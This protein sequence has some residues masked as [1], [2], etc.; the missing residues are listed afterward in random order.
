MQNRA[1]APPAPKAIPFGA[2]SAIEQ[3]MMVKLLASLPNKY[4]S[5][6]VHFYNEKRYPEAGS[7]VRGSIRRLTLPK[8]SYSLLYRVLEE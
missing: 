8:F 1:I 4:F 2:P 6:F 7:N 5:E 3:W